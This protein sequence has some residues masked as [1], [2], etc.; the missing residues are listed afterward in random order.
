M[1]FTN[2]FT[3]LFLQNGA[4]R[5]Y[6]KSTFDLSDTDI[7]RA[8]SVSSQKPKYSEFFALSSNMSQ[9]FRL[10]PTEKFYE[11]ANT[12]NISQKQKKKEEVAE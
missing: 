7:Y 12:E 4:T 10:Y 9:V 5:E 11:L 6:L 1:I 3:K 8:L 2:S